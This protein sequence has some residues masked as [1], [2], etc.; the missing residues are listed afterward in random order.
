MQCAQLEAKLGSQV[1]FLGYQVYDTEQDATTV[2]TG[3]S[4]SKR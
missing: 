1:S 4:K 3:Q 2:V